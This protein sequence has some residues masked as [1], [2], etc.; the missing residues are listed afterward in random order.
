MKKILILTGRYLPGYKDGGPVRTLI[1]LT[2]LLGDEYEFYL[3]VLDRDHGDTCAYPN[4][5]RNEWNTVGKAKVWYYAPGEM[6][7][8][9]IL[10]LAKDKDLIYTCGFYDGYGYKTLWLNKRKKLFGKPVV[11]A[12]M[13]TFSENALRQKSFKKKLFITLCKTLG[14]FK[15]ITWSVTSERE[16]KDVKKNIGEKAKCIIAEDPPRSS[17]RVVRQEYS[18]EGQLKI[19]FLSRISPI[20]NLLFAIDILSKIKQNVDFDIYGPLEDASYWNK[21]IDKLKALPINIKWKY[22]GE[23]ATEEVPAVFSKYDVFLFPTLGENFGHVIFEALNSG[24]IPIISDKTPWQ[25]FN[26]KKSGFVCELED[27]A[28]FVFAVESICNM[29]KKQKK[30]FGKNCIKYATN[31]ILQT[32]QNTGYR[33]IFDL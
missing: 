31:K 5:K 3:A 11:V 10:E 23:T 12:A 16:A 18:D 1:N 30:E 4:I 21:C 9:F 7:G 27:I 17:G 28:Q 8:K 19:V 33:K 20:K 25:D 13:G 6:N 29:P 24:C 22:C 14:L 26:E 15:N 32:K 2:D